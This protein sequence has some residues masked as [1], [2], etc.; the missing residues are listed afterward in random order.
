M[1]KLL[2]ILLIYLCSS[3]SVL[4]QPQCEAKDYQQFDF[5]VGE[6]QVS[7]SKNPQTSRS[8]IS[9]ILSG[10]V[11]LEEY[12]APTG[13]QGKSLNIY[14]Q[15]TQQWHQTWTDN[16]G[17]LLQLNGRLI[18]GSMV[19]MGAIENAKGEV[20]LQRITWTPLASGDVRQ[21]WQQSKDDGSNWVTLFDG[22][23]QKNKAN[24]DG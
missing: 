12:T 2:T 17:M 18:D 23:Y 5:W 9:K 13:Y 15:H 6:W 16:D 3:T 14:N 24:T 4:A 20:L 22:N 19:L 11:I 8:K 1:N 10:C 21:H 7:N